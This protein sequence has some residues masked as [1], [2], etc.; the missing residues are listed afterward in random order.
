MDSAVGKAVLPEDRFSKVVKYVLNIQICQTQE[1][2]F[3]GSYGS[4]YLHDS[5]CISQNQANI[6]LDVSGLQT[7]S[8]QS[9]NVS[10]HALKHS[11]FIDVVASYR[12]YSQ[13]YPV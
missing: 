10:H 4:Y 2:I 13:R 7:T 12:K 11:E 5:T 3:S 6:E 1:V 8:G 9:L